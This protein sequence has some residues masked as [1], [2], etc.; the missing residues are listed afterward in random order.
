MANSPVLTKE[1]LK[2]M[3]KEQP[4]V[5]A[6]ALKNKKYWH[7]RIDNEMQ[8]IYDNAMTENI[9][10]KKIYQRAYENMNREMAAFIQKY[11]EEGVLTRSEYYAFNRNFQVIEN[12][13]RELQKVGV[14]EDKF[15][16]RSLVK[17]YKQA[18]NTMGKDLGLIL[19]SNIKVSAAPLEAAKRVVNLNLQGKNFSTRI[20]DNKKKALDRIQETLEDAVAKNLSYDKAS[21]LLAE[22]MSVSYND[23]DRLIATEMNHVITEAQADSMRAYG[24]QRYEIIAVMD[25]RTTEICQTMDGKVFNLSEKEPG[26]NA[27]PFHVRCRTTIA[28]AVYWEE[29][30]PQ[31]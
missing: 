15:I 13:R 28:P 8:S 16:N 9:R 18:Y 2:K 1:I 22:R 10:L 5:Y 31:E 25:N 19:R 24:I 14:A 29:L 27:P 12:M 23:A 30:I 3:K 4:D 21:K 6:Q 20:W 11:G 7:K 26:L 17:R